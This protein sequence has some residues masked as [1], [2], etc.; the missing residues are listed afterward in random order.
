MSVAVAIP[1]FAG[2]AIALLSALGVMAAR[3]AFDRMHFVGPAAVLTPV[4][5]AIA[6][7]IAGDSAQSVVKAMLLAIIYLA[8]SPILAHATGK[9]IYRREL[10]IRQGRR[11]GD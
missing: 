11:V 4:L 1:L 5:L 9:A 6:I 7:G 2:V 3:D 10:R 8:V